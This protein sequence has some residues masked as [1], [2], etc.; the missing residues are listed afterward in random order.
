MHP[1]RWIFGAILLCTLMAAAFLLRPSPPSLL[2]NSRRIVGARGWYA[3]LWTGQLVVERSDGL[4]GLHVFK[5]DR[6]GR[7]SLSNNPTLA[8]ALERAAGEKSF[9]RISPN[10]QWVL[11]Q[12]ET[13]IGS[14]GTLHKAGNPE[15]TQM[16]FVGSDSKWLP[17]S[18]GF[19]T[20]LDEGNM[21]R[22]TVYSM[23]ETIGLRTVRPKLS[24]YSPV[25]GVR[26]GSFQVNSAPTGASG[27]YAVRWPTPP[28]KLVGVT[29]QK[30]AILTTWQPGQLRDLDIFE[31]SLEE[32]RIPLNV[33]TVE[34]PAGYR[35]DEVAFSPDGR[36]IAMR[37]YSS[38]PESGL[39]KL[40][41]RLRL[42]RPSR[43]PS[44]DEI[45]ISDVSGKL[46]NRLG[47][48]AGPPH[49]SSTVLGVPHNLQWLP[50]NKGISF[51]LNDILYVVDATT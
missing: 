39:L 32:S 40:L 17:D 30:T 24:P 43:R 16:T 34:I 27:S 19:V 51:I 13:H 49:S 14:F 47:A 38:A 8:R 2:D 42:Y 31:V 1:R 11:K 28:S 15:A 36:R 37:L 26:G 18:S 45:W 41:E 50:D 29:A 20:L 7:L 35:V 46:R 23:D 44:R 21:P 48:I 10:G 33:S 22:L 12:S 9:G 25:R 3:W 5:P 6:S 4:P